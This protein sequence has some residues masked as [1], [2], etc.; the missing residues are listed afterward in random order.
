[1]DRGVKQ[2]KRSRIQIIKVSWESKRGR[3]FTWEP[4]DLNEI[5]SSL[6]R[7]YFCLISRWNS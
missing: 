1:M 2:L 4:E 6:P 7:A 3:E 5:P